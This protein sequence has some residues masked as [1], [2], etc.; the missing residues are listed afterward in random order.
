MYF[1]H[2]TQ[3]LT[4]TYLKHFIVKKLKFLLKMGGSVYNEVYLN[5]TLLP[6]FFQE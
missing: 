5:G 6:S 4:L 3:F 1:P 2:L